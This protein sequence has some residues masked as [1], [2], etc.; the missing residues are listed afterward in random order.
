MIER[1]LDLFDGHGYEKGRPVAVQAMWL[2]ASHLL[3]QPWWAPSALRV[4]ALRLF[5]ARIGTGVVIRSGV[6]VH[7]PWK[8]RIG[9]NVW[10]GEDAWLL[11]LE[12]IEL[13]DQVCISQGAMLCTGSHDQSAVDFAFDNGPIVVESGSW[14]C[15]RATVLRGVRVG[16]GSVVGAGVVVRK[17][18][19]PSTMLS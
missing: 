3:V 18:L 10:L 9:S 13:G 8:L 19:P 1:R 15:A 14:I 2:A 16:A 7:W 11:N 4:A 12:P 5:G 6:R 17:D